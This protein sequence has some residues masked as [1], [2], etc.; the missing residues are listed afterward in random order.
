[1]GINAHGERLGRVLGLE[2][3]LRFA[4]EVGPSI[5]DAGVADLV[6]V[7]HTGVGHGR[8]EADESEEEDVDDR[9]RVGFED[10]IREKLGAIYVWVAPGGS[11]GRIAWNIVLRRRIL[12]FC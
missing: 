5:E 4:L 3:E 9:H 12:S 1:M 6:V 8:R 7:D 11:L 2:D 10:G